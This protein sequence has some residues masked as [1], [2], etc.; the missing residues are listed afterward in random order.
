MLVLALI[1]QL[2]VRIATAT[3]KSAVAS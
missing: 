2:V 3:Q 1:I